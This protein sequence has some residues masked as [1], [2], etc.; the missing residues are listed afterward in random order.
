MRKRMNEI[1]HIKDHNREWKEIDE[2]IQ[3]V[4]EK[5]FG[6]LFATSSSD[7][8]LADR[9]WVNQISDAENMELISEVTIDEVNEAIFSMHPNKLPGL[10]PGGVNRS[11]VYLIPKIKMPQTMTGLRPISLCNVLVRIMSKVMSIHLKPVLNSIASDKQSAF[12][13]VTYS[14]MH[15]GGAFGDLKPQRGLHQGDPIAPYIY[16]MYAE[17][18]SAMIRRNEEVGILHGCTVA[19]GAPTISH[20]LFADD[21]YFF[22]RATAAEAGVMHQ[23]LQ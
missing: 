11:L 6:E 22:F 12:I 16:I 20:L 3:V 1:R 15:N 17:G 14:F 19:S 18:L 9:E 13:A 4:I 21:A 23:I 5:Y 2:E 8:K 7:G 10:L